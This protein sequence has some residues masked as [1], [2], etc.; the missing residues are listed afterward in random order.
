MYLNSKFNILS[1]TENAM[2]VCDSIDI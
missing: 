2:K 1:F